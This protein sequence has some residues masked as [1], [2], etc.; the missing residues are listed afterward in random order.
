[1]EDLVTRL[2][3]ASQPKLLPYLPCM[4]AV[5]QSNFA[6]TKESASVTVSH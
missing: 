3:T 6:E 4:N 5:V 1:M 2:V